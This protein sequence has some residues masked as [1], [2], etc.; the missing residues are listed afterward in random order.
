MIM[1][2]YIKV[3]K[4]YVTFTGRARRKEFWMF[5]LFDFLFCIITA[6]LDILLGTSFKQTLYGT[7]VEYYYGWIYVVYSLAVFMPGLAVSVRRLHDIG[8]SGWYLLISLIPIVGAIIVL[9][10]DCKEGDKGDNKYGSDPK[11]EEV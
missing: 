1:K 4:N 8:K 7:A 3:L 9:V 2:W 5:F 11:L 6:I 10:W